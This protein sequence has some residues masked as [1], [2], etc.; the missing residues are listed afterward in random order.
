[1]GLFVKHFNHSVVLEQHLQYSIDIQM[2][3]RAKAPQCR[4]SR[5][6][7]T[8]LECLVMGLGVVALEVDL[9]YRGIKGQLSPQMLFAISL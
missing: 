5:T 1:M 9:G 2:G 3:E 4:C 7:V 6:K 8:P